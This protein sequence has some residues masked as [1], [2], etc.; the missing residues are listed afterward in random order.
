MNEL[1][2]LHTRHR[3]QSL[4]WQNNGAIPLW[5]A[6]MDFKCPDVV[7]YTMEK[8]VEQGVFGYPIVGE[9]YFI[10]VS[11]WF[12]KYHEY[13]L[14][15]EN[16]IPVTGTLA[17][18]RAIIE[19]FSQERDS[20]LVQSPVYHMFYDVIKDSCRIPLVNELQHIDCGYLID[21]KHLEL[22]L[23]IKPKLFIL[24][25]P[26][27][28]I[29][30]IWSE[31]ELI[32]IAQLCIKYKVLLVVDEIHC[33]LAFDNKKFTSLA[34]LAEEVLQN[35]IVLTSPTKTFNLAGVRGG[36]MFVWN[37]EIKQR[38]QKR[39]V[40]FGMNKLN[41]FYI[42]ATKSAYC[43]GHEWL[44]EVK[45]YIFDNYLYV[46]EFFHKE[47]PHLKLCDMQATYLM[48]INYKALNLSEEIFFRDLDSKVALAK[49]SQFGH[50]GIG[51]FRIDLF[52]NYF[53]KEI[54]RIIIIKTGSYE[55]RKYQRN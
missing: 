50:N 19:E 2:L 54:F 34:T 25:S 16:I 38:M 39:I 1:G 33:D 40:R 12:C 51:F 6:D 29:G 21:F 31:I 37:E 5:L 9:E 11:S 32:Q 24:C 49:G 18:L 3:Y 43:H 17:A 23:S 44:N 47:I 48:W 8:L 42:S 55:I 13:S 53:I 27:N 14:K 46:R 7:L 26:H 22:C 35:L 28:P 41:I 52:G 10:S 45:K 36:N 15:E 20:I 4:K 30:K